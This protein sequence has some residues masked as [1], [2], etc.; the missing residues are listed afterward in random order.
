MSSS[1][2]QK[3]SCVS[4]RVTGSLSL[5]AIAAFLNNSRSSA[6][7]PGHRLLLTSLSGGLAL[8]SVARAGDLPP[9]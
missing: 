5:L 4:C 7:S 3:S 6:K 2:T 1:D 9:F 8:L